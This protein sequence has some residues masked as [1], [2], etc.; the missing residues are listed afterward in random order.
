[1][2]PWLGHDFRVRHTALE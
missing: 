1:M 2:P